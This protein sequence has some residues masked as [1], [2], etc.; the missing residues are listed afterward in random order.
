VIGGGEDGAPV[1]VA[2]LNP[3]GSARVYL[4]NLGN[5]GRNLGTGVAADAA[6]NAYVTGAIN[7]GH[8]PTTAGAF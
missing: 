6:G 8:F 7:G 5:N 3:D 4:T 1:W 2:K